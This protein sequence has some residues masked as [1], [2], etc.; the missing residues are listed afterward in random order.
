[1]ICRLSEFP[2]RTTLVSY[3]WVSCHQGKHLIMP[4]I[5]PFG[6]D[7]NHHSRSLSPFDIKGKGKT[8]KFS[9]WVYL[10]LSILP[11]ST[12]C[13][14]WLSS[15]FVHSKMYQSVHA[16]PEVFITKTS[17]LFKTMILISHYHTPY[18]IC[19]IS[20]N[21]QSCNLQYHSFDQAT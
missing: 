5:S 16:P 6:L 4:I 11:L 3:L 20:I 12:Y 2:S 15:P 14:L 19:T 13:N 17:N 8:E 1:M 18:M 9:P 10:L 21:I 7:G